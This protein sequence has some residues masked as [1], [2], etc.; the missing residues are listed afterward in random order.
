MDKYCKYAFKA[1][2]YD[3]DRVRGQGKQKKLSFIVKAR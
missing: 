3:S 1:E 2:K